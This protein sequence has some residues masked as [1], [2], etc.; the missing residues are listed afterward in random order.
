MSTNL[1]ILSNSSDES[2]GAALAARR[3]FRLFESPNTFQLT[4]D[5]L[6][7]NVSFA[8]GLCNKIFKP[9]LYI[10]NP[11]VYFSV[12]RFCKKNR[13]TNCNLHLF[14]GG[15]TSSAVL[16][17]KH[18]GVYI[19]HTVHDYRNICSINSMYTKSGENCTRCLSSINSVL[20]SSCS[21]HS[22]FVTFLIWLESIIRIKVLGVYSIIDKYHF[23][24]NFC[25]DI[26]IE[27]SADFQRS[28]YLQ[29]F[30]N[31]TIQEKNAARVFDSSNT[32]LYVGRLSQEK[33]LLP[34]IKELSSSQV[35]F[36]IYGH[37]PQES[38]I[39]ELISSIDNI[40]LFGPID[41]ASV[42]NLIRSYKFLILP[43]LWFENNP[44]SAIEAMST[45]TPIITSALGGLPELTRHGGG[46]TYTSVN[47]IVPFL[48]SLTKEMYLDYTKRAFATASK[49]NS[50][51]SY[52]HNFI[53]QFDND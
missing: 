37:G 46:F 22:I 20:T 2:G 42:L 21:K 24:S 19:I 31:I 18:S 27:A 26:H 1:L 45:S 5:S 14:V 17:L 9:F 32:L 39:T 43:S 41:N 36:H 52:S 25:R 28:F 47:E 12:K 50:S 35:A 11:F 49:Y 16:A 53:S 34:I 44:L 10:F 3:S 23:V 29:N 38:E 13:I 15:L 4:F 30:I 6:N 51:V 40:S 7:S 33:G 8:H 48:S